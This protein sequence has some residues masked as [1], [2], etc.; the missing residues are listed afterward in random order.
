MKELTAFIKE[1]IQSEDLQEEVSLALKKF[2]SVR[3]GFKMA[4]KQ[5]VIDALYQLGFDFVEDESSDDEFVFH[6]EYVDTYYDVILHLKDHVSGKVK[7]HNI[8]VTE[9]E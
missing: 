6:G 4:P 1:S 9:A 8:F 3:N 2:G 5:D 7:I